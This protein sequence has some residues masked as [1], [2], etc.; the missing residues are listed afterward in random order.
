MLFS[1]ALLVLGS[2]HSVANAFELSDVSRRDAIESAIAVPFQASPKNEV[3]RLG[4]DSAR[5]VVQRYFAKQPYVRVDV[6]S[7][8]LESA[9]VAADR[10]NRGHSQG[11]LVN[12]ID[13]LEN[14][15][16][17]NLSNALIREAGEKCGKQKEL[18]VNLSY[19]GTGRVPVSALHAQILPGLS[20]QTMFETDGVLEGATLLIANYMASPPNC[21]SSTK[22]FSVC[23]SSGCE[24]ILQSID[25]RLQAPA[26]SPE[27]LVRFISSSSANVGKFPKQFERKLRSM[28]DIDQGL[29][30]LRDERFAEW[31]HY[32]FPDSCAI[33]HGIAETLGMEP[34]DGT[35]TVES[36]IDLYAG[37]AAL[38]AESQSKFPALRIQDFV[39]PL[40]WAL[41]G[42]GMLR[43][44]LS[45]AHDAKHRLDG[46]SDG[47][48][49]KKA[50]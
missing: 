3:G 46:P 48:D 20:D 16:P 12:A 6:G 24:T 26:V 10:W 43:A 32:A 27:R 47:S 17:S 37:E 45:N 18:L 5:S 13:A 49:L 21:L 41:I 44:A 29:V 14:L 42:I 2:C 30:P 36:M 38:G 19:P 9:L 28:A 25:A 7:G 22:D 39:R 50:T 1:T 33:R 34:D 11:D 4:F 15:M 8:A 23:C 35:F 40:V 31:L